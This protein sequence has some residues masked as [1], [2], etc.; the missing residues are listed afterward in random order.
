MNIIIKLGGEYKLAT[1][2]MEPYDLPEGYDEEKVREARE[3]ERRIQK[4][5]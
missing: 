2:K 1:G 5:L 3:A 4:D